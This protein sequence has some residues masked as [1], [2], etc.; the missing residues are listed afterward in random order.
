MEQDKPPAVP[1]A[2][3][4][5]SPRPKPLEIYARIALLLSF[6]SCLFP[7]IA[8]AAIVLA[9]AGIVRMRKRQ[10]RGRDCAV[11][12]IVLSLIGTLLFLK[13][14]IGLPAT[15]A[16]AINSNCQANL[17]TI[18]QIMFIYEADY[19]NAKGY[20]LDDLVKFSKTSSP[21]LGVSSLWCPNCGDRPPAAPG[22]PTPSSYVLLTPL[23]PFSKLPRTTIVAIELGIHHIPTDG[24][25]PERHG[26]NVLFADGHIDMIPPD[27]IASEI[28][29]SL[30]TS[31]P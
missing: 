11:T 22:L 29:K 31:K 23:E 30:N 4:P 27:K 26:T 25:F 19:R 21:P 12:A 20:S 5:E 8:A 18:G 6:V 17:R 16:A 28:E 24:E 13:I 2:N 14:A 9:I 15:R 10:T 1:S 3:P 7:L